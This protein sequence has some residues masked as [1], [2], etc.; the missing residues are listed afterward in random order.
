MKVLVLGGS[1]MLGHKLWQTLV[2]RF[3]TWVT[4]RGPTNIYRD[5]GLFDSSRTLT[6]V[7]ADSFDSVVNA[8]A[9][10]KP[11]LVVNCIGIVKQDP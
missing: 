9:T 8:L 11:D 4:F 10:T 5:S 7:R 3:D 6:S 2:S 1:G